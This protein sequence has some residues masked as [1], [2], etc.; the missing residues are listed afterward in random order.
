MSEAETLIKPQLPD[1]LD[2]PELK[3]PASRA[4]DDIGFDL[5][6]GDGHEKTGSRGLDLELPETRLEP[7]GAAMGAT[8]LGSPATPASRAPID[9]GSTSKIN[10]TVGTTGDVSSVFTIAGTGEPG[11]LIESGPTDKIFTNPTEQATED[12][13]SG[14]FG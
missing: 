1:A 7:A 9:F 10:V 3:V 6:L 11:R 12:Y 13:I 8:T 5:N 14:R 4:P 2:L